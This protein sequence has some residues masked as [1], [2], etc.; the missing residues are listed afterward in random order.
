MA[1]H[2]IWARFRCLRPSQT[3]KRGSRRVSS[4]SP[5]YRHRCCTVKCWVAGFVVTRVVVVAV[6]FWPALVV[7][8]V[9]VRVFV[10]VDVFVA[11]VV[12]VVAVVVV[13]VPQ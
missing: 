10:V 7:V 3:T 12:V 1:R 9:V 13:V 5:C 4:S 6:S 2:V 8:V 11:V